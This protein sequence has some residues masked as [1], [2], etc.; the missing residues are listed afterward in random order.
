[1]KNRFIIM[2]SMLGVFSFAQEEMR[3]SLEEAIQHTLSH[4]FDMLK[5]D[6]EIEK[7]ESMGNNR[8]RFTAYRWSYRLS[9]QYSD[10]E[11]FLD[12]YCFPSR[13]ETKYISFYSN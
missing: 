12:G 7:A 1:M 9:E 6:L 3:F 5:A 8:N 11:D 10:A 2:L 4:N 13:T